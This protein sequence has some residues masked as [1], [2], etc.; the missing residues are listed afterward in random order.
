MNTVE[1]E[2]SRTP[3]IPEE[4]PS[5]QSV[6]EVAVLAKQCQEVLGYARMQGHAE[7]VA[8]HRARIARRRSLQ[9]VLV[10]LEIEPYSRNIIDQYKAEKLREKQGKWADRMGQAWAWSTFGKMTS[11]VM[12]GLAFMSVVISMGG[13]GHIALIAWIITVPYFVCWLCLLKW[14]ANGPRG[15]MQWAWRAYGTTDYSRPVPT[16]ATRKAIQIAKAYPKAR[17][18]VEELSDEQMVG[19]PF[20]VVA[21]NDGQW[22]YVEVWGEPAF[23]KKL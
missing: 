10:E 8:K 19:D 17:L 18:L 23:E 20:L 4:V 12:M 15:A 3:I 5:E 22:L 9:D 14:L 2:S 13:A 21:D 11:A 7:S 16:F 1:L 6:E